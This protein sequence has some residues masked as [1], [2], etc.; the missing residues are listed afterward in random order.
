VPGLSSA[1]RSYRLERMQGL[2]RD[3]DC[4][5]LALAGADWFEWAANHAISVL[6]WERPFL[7][8]VT[9][10]GSTLALLPE[11][12]RN[13]IDAERR[14]GTLWVDALAF[15]AESTDAARHKWIATQWREMVIDA[16]GSCGLSR[17]RIG[18]DAVPD[19]LQSAAAADGITA[20][21]LGNPLRSL[22]RVKHPEEIATMRRCASLSD[23]AVDVYRQ[24]LRPGRLLAEADFLVSARL[25]VEAARRHPGENFVIGR[26]VT[27][28]GPASA[29]PHGDG[30]P[31]GK[32]L[33]RD[34]IAT[35]TLATRLNGLAMELARPWLVGSP[36]AETI[37]LLDCVRIAQDAAI[38]AAVAG[39]AIAGMHRAAQDVLEGA[40]LGAQ[41]RVRAG[42]AIGVA[43]HDF[44]ENVPF[45]DRTF[46]EQETYVV[47]PAIYPP[48]IG[49]FRFADAI[50]IR[51]GAPELLTLSPKSRTAQRLR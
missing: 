12:S 26:L 45:D 51:R 49:A 34:A 37:R 46:L 29:C 50:A 3:H 1:V 42:H 19:W 21:K 36:G 48:E 8:I 23:W 35:T 44:P 43:M 17:A 14:R 22:R 28:S 41:L 9:L 6:S 11:L 7:L 33:E 25:A 13:A 10:D 31:N 27:H 5:A 20:V 16:L 2:M 47:E 32:V 38:D 40:G 24:E 15:Y 30:A 39:R 18:A 4:A